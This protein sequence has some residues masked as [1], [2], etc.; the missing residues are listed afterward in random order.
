MAGRGGLNLTHSEPLDIFL[1]RYGAAADA[2]AP[3]LR[4]FPPRALRDWCDGLGEESFTGSSGRVFPKSFKAS[5]LLRAWL[6]RLAA[7]GVSFR[8]NCEWT[9]WDESGRLLFSGAEP[10]RADAALLALGGASW[11]RLGADGSWAKRC[12]PRI[13]ALPSTGPR[14]F[15]ISS[16]GSRSSRFRFPSPGAAFR[17]RR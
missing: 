4:A 15:A 7:Q 14:I 8:F 9:G 16:R 6:A 3:A 2:L 13:A 5:P 1:T 17:A 10:A 12:G 11:P